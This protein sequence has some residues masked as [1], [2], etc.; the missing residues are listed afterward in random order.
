MTFFGLIDVDWWA[1]VLAYIGT[2][3]VAAILLLFI[4]AALP[5]RR[6]AHASAGH[7]HSGAHAVD[8]EAVR[9][10]YYPLAAVLTAADWVT[11]DQRRYRKWGSK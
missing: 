3:I 4:A 1:A 9:W 11:S 7:D 8:D 2:G 10:F 5:D 6:A